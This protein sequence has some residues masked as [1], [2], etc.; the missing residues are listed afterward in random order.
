MDS[1]IIHHIPQ[2][3]QKWAKSLTPA[4]IAKILTI[5]G[6]SWSEASTSAV[7]S[8]TIGILGEQEVYALIGSKYR[9][10]D[11]AK[12]GKMGDFIII[13][14][15]I[16]ILIEVKKYKKTVPSA[17]I[18]KFYRDIN[19]NGSVNGGLFI[20]LTS[21][22]VGIHESMKYVKSPTM[23]RV[24][25]IFV[26]YSTKVTIMAGIDILIA[27]LSSTRVNIDDQIIGTID[28]IT[29]IIDCIS[30]CRN[31]LIDFQGMVNK[32]FIKVIGEIMSAEMKLVKSVEILNA[33]V[34]MEE[35]KRS[36]L[37]ELLG[38]FSMSGDNE[39]MLNLILGDF[40]EGVQAGN[41]IKLTKDKSLVILKSQIKFVFKTPLRIDD[42]PVVDLTLIGGRWSYS[43]GKL[44]IPL[45]Q[46]NINII[47]TLLSI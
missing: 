10:I 40:K 16:K 8:A 26:T 41:E 21:N 39:T 24:P 47:Q 14:N 44:T 2:K 22:I 46:N 27:K 29:R 32:Q 37:V 35:V 31:I 17:E 34:H 42:R 23:N 4:E 12:N 1:K 9:I 18:D 45:S 43:A 5:V 20:S 3:L 38:G 7:S 28:S 36:P 19:A 11:T 30:G 13:I 6:N 33:Q 25:V 15:G